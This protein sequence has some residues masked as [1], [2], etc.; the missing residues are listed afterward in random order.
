MQAQGQHQTTEVSALASLSTSLTETQVNSIDTS[1]VLSTGPGIT[2]ADSSLLG[3]SSVRHN[4]NIDGN[5]DTSKMQEAE[6]STILSKKDG[7]NQMETKNGS[8][9]T[10]MNIH[11]AQKI[12]AVDE[13][14]KSGRGRTSKPDTAA[15]T[16]TTTTTTLSDSTKKEKEE[17]FTVSAIA[18]RGRKRKEPTLEK[19]GSGSKDSEDTEVREEGVTNGG[20][21][22]KEPVIEKLGSSSKDSEDTEVGE[23][24]IIVELKEK[25][26]KVTKE[27][28]TKD[29]K[30]KD[31]GRE[32]GRGKAK[33]KDRDKDNT[34]K[35]KQ[36]VTAA[37]RGLAAGRP[38]RGT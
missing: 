4:R 23:A 20:R 37:T 2:E 34:D 18:G 32:K 10:E 21:K 3:S 8:E 31:K 12:A 28:K 22:R 13:K 38:R 26:G 14:N 1:V 30:E 5:G 36:T 9:D 27:K 16:T 7:L 17:T 6:E 25:A 19:L 24:E 15:T 29:N 35:D 11:A 33:E